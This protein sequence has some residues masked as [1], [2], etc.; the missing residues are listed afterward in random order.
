MQMIAI[1]NDCTLIVLMLMNSLLR[2][3]SLYEDT[4]D[5]FDSMAVGAG[6]PRIELYSPIYL[7][8][9]CNLSTRV[10]THV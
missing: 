9:V 5:K 8:K 7:S 6:H 4:I 1:T 2:R 3:L 10:P